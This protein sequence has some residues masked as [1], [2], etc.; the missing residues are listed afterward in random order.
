VPIYVRMLRLRDAE[1]EKEYRNREKVKYPEC[2]GL[3]R[4][5]RGLSVGE[6][7]S[8]CRVCPHFSK[9][10]FLKIQNKTKEEI[11]MGKKKQGKNLEVKNMDKKDKKPVK[12]KEQERQEKINKMI[13]HYEHLK[14]AARAWL[15]IWASK[16]YVDMAKVEELEKAHS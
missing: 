4:E 2:L 11:D 1:I 13:E 15:K 12:D 5:C 6:T 16:G 10:Y 7:C 3:F 8:D 14:P 9:A